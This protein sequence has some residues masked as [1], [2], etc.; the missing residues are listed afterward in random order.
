MRQ[1]VDAP[2][3]AMAG[4]KRGEIL[5][6][7][8][9]PYAQAP[10]GPL[11]FAPP[12]PLGRWEGVRDASVSGPIPPQGKSRLAAV[13]GGDV[14]L[15]Q[16]EDCL[17]LE[18]T[19]RSTARAGRPVMVWIHGG[20]FMG[21][22]GSH[23]WYAGD[24]LAARGDVVLVNV[25]FRQGVLGHIYVPG[26]SAGNMALLDIVAALQWI[27]RNVS[28]FGGDP[29][30]VTVFGQSSGAVAVAA[31][32]AMPSAKGLLR[33]AILQSAPLGR[34]FKTPAEAAEIGSRYL[35]LLK[36]TPG[37]AGTLRHLHTST[38]LI[39]QGELVR[40]LR[41]PAFA[42]GAQAFGPIVDG[43]HLVPAAE[44]WAHAQAS[45]VDLLVGT[46]RDEQ[47]APFAIDPSVQQATS[48]QVRQG[49]AHFAGDAMESVWKHYES[50]LPLPAPSAMLG[51]L[52]SDLIFRLPSIALVQQHWK[53][54]QRSWLY[55]FDWPSPAGFGA[56]HCLELPF[57]FGEFG[58]YADAPMLK[59][60]DEQQFRGLS[61]RIQDAWL[62]FAHTGSPA[63]CNLPSWPVY[64]QEGRVT[65]RFDR[66][67]EP[68][69]DLA[70]YA[71][72]PLT[73]DSA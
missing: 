72:H 35:S 39:A 21:G 8:N 11:R 69:R 23:P 58:N 49:F 38:L 29:A 3:G 6:Y 56:C 18:V 33:R 47:A 9:I 59:G 37:E 62:S 36:I 10:V 68:I 4:A 30:N 55:Q 12:Q 41:H 27:Q 13:T 48:E 73:A 70:G 17:T 52:Y 14:E 15:A 40:S 60:L 61:E 31:L 24:Q 43:S 64:G 65:M 42:Y 71:T 20:G 67:I 5:I 2:C 44:G 19:C 26:V 50:R 16:S 25:N 63:H 45:G 28:V 1:N 66:H 46:L 32:L 22:A 34:P 54:G 53:A 51:D 7:R 57:V